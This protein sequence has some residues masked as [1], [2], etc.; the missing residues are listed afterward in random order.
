MELTLVDL[1]K[2]IIEIKEL[3]SLNRKTFNAKQAANYLS[4]SYDTI[5]RLARI[6]DIDF[7][8][9]GTSYIFRRRHLDEWLDKQERRAK[10]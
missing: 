5:T 4:V 6:G 9:N 1:H 2:E 10:R 3:A 7:V 8:K